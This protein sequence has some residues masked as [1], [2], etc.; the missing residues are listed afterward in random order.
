MSPLLIFSAAGSIGKI[1]EIAGSGARG[2]GLPH[3]PYFR[4]RADRIRWLA[5]KMAAG[6]KLPGLV[7]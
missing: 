4:N 6:P 7:S 5:S 1:L 2:F 3:N